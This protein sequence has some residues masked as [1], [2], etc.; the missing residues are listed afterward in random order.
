MPLSEL[1]R[2]RDLVRP[3]AWPSRLRTTGL[4]VLTLSDVA[5]A[6][7]YHDAR[8]AFVEGR[9]APPGEFVDALAGL[10]ALLAIALPI[11]VGFRRRI[12]MWVAITGALGTIVLWLGPT[13]ALIG[14]YQVILRRPRADAWRVG[15]AVTIAT[16]LCTWRDLTS[17]APGSSFW[18]GLIDAGPGIA[19]PIPLVVTAALVGL[20]VGAALWTRTRAVL[21]ETVIEVG[22][23]RQHVSDLTDQLSRQAERERIARE[24]HDGLG[25]R[26]SLLSVHAGALQAVAS[27]EPD[28]RAAH[29]I[30]TSAA[31]IRESASESMNEL[32]S[33]L[34]LLRNPGDPDIVAPMAT[35]RDVSTLIDDS[36]AAGMPLVATVFV[37][38]AESLDPQHAQA[39]FR[40]VQELLTNARKHAPG[41]AVRLS[42]TGG[43][44]LGSLDIATA[45]HLPRDP[46]LPGPSD[47]TPPSRGGSGLA[48]IHERIERLGGTMHSGIDPT[49]VFR[50]QVHLPWPA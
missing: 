48:G 11:L 23:E 12:P 7:G 10:Y 36:V 18:D 1:P 38:E 49:G 40:V 19:R 43:P 29:E 25:H 13:V 5:L 44:G 15:V 8:V 2:G 35:L 50:V 41:L 21:A 6:A 27:E 26:L 45:N 14:L 22:T 34:D 17:S 47:P 46:A 33:L 9:V 4:V 39:A 31:L 3:T 24:I 42:V 37:D 20:A 28:D 30:R 32:H 16:G